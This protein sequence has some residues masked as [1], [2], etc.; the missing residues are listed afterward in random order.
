MLVNSRHNL[1]P[2]HVQRNHR[3]ERVQPNLRP[4]HDR[5]N[6]RQ[7]HEQ[8][9]LQPERDP[10]PET[11]FRSYPTTDHRELRTVRISPISVNSD[12]RKSTTT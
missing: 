1:R 6:L 7:V 2:E 11:T 10:A 12:M 3:Q 9:N 4:G 8:R 5:P